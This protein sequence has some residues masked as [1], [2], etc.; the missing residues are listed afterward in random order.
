MMERGLVLAVSIALVALLGAG[1]TAAARTRPRA[2][3]AAYSRQSPFV[4]RPFRAFDGDRWI[5]EAVAYGPHRDGQR[6]GALSPTRAQMREDL[7]IMSKHWSLLRIYGSVGTADT[8]L[9]AIRE[10]K[11]RTKIVLGLSL[12]AEDRR[13]S[14]GAVIERFPEAVKHNRA[15]IEAAVRHARLNPG[16]VLAIAVGNETQI[17]WAGI[18]LP[19]ER[20]IGYIREMRAR[21]KVPVST[22]DDFNFWNKEESR[23]IALECDYVF[24][25][26]HP[27][28]NGALNDDALPWVERNLGAIRLMHPEREVVIGETGWA[29]QRNDQG[30]QGKLM[31]G[32]LGE[33]EQAA[34]QR[35]LRAWIAQHRVPTFVFEAFDEN[36]KGSPDP[37]EVE[38]HWGLYRA[39]RTPKL[40]MTE[41]GK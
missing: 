26:L 22:A 7:E 16:A 41:A 4:V 29:T 9:A 30:D 5:G 34:F 20:L 1:V 28:W 8:L 18:R 33:A 36:W 25:H 38:K 21:T 37:A 31:K 12:A 32:A 17:H 40:A 19:S 2:Q 35:A 27:L 24:T 15:E 10:T 11:S 39:D 23:A 6:P 13:D 14:T 3:A